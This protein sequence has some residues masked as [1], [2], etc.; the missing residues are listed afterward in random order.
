MKSGIAV[1]VAV[2]FIAWFL[3]I[4]RGTK[5]ADKDTLTC[6]LHRAWRRLAS[7]AGDVHV[8][9]QWYFGVVPLPLVSWTKHEYAVTHE[10]L[11]A[12]SK[13]LQ[14][15][16]IILTTKKGYL[17]S[18]SAIPG[19]FKHA[20]IISAGPGKHHVIN[21]LRRSDGSGYDTVYEKLIYDVSVTRVVEAISEGVVMRHPQWGRADYMIFL[22]PKHMEHYERLRA[23]DTA[24][25]L[26]GCRYDVTFKFNIEAE[27]E[28]LNGETRKM[29]RE[30]FQEE[31]DELRRLE[32]NHQGEYDIAFSC[33]EAVAAA[34][35][36]RRKQLGIFR[37]HIR[38]RKCIIADQFVNRDMEV[39]WTNVPSSVA[40]KE[41][42]HEEGL[43]ELEA[44]ERRK[45]VDLEAL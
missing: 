32:A 20:M 17:L 27:L 10:M 3:W 24:K 14:P 35:W 33:T 31:V 22:R 16:D 21:D 8:S 45:H 26:V 38:G 1:A 42:M 40:R 37:K 34:W 7:W 25:R 41:G 6:R 9:W 15:G 18:N 12:A 19:V 44:Y 11:L 5:D 43:R 39:L 23:A 29:D 13:L 36:F 4:S 2:L 30:H 28:L